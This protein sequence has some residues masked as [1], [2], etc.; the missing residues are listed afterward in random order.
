M[1]PSSPW[2][3][4]SVSCVLRSAADPNRRVSSACR[5]GAP[6]PTRLGGMNYTAILIYCRAFKGVVRAWPPTTRF[7][8]ENRISSRR[9]RPKGP[10]ATCGRPTSA[11]SALP[12]CCSASCRPVPSASRRS[13]PPQAPGS[14]SSSSWCCPSCGRVPSAGSWP[15]PT[16]SCRGKAASTPGPRRPSGSSGGFRPAGG[17]PWTPTSPQAPTSPWWAATPPSCCPSMP[18]APSW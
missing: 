7:L 12:S 14:P 10:S 6:A 8:P 5:R 2:A 18:R 17:P 16:P 13:F 11:R 4:G 15:R 9:P 3:A 1:T